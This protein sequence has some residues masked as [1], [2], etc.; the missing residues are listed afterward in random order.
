MAEKTINAN[1]FK[2]LTIGM[3]DAVIGDDIIR[4]IQT[5]LVFVPTQA[6]LAKLADYPT[7]T[8]AATYGAGS[9]WQKK[10]DGTWA[11]V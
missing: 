1:A 7:G 11:S 5:K 10:P 9:M 4:D 2:A 6:D 8:F 3:H